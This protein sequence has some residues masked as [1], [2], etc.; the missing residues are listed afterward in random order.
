MPEI[1]FAEPKTAVL[2]P[3]LGAAAVVTTWVMVKDAAVEVLGLKLG[4][5]L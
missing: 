3:P 1:R 4:S 5:P 2:F